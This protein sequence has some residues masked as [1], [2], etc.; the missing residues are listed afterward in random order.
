MSK[1][2]DTSNSIQQP[3]RGILIFNEKLSRTKTLFNGLL[4]VQKDGR[5][6]FYHLR[7]HSV[8][9]TSQ[10]SLQLCAANFLKGVKL[11]GVEE[12]SP[13]TMRCRKS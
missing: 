5:A 13:S 10:A 9:D 3:L 11:K 12:W 7:G 2:G 8:D 1:A 6:L 4:A